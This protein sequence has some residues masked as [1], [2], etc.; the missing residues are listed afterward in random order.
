MCQG[1]NI[2]FY[3]IRTLQG[4]NVALYYKAANK[5]LD[6]VSDHFHFWSDMNLA[7]AFQL[8]YRSYSL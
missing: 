8:V 6:K 7:L 4:I 5:Y 1:I 3:Y 2:A